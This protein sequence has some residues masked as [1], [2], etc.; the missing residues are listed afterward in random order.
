[1][2][3]GRKV[4]CGLTSSQH[5]AYFNEDRDE[6]TATVYFRNG[7]RTFEEIALPE[8]PRCDEIKDEDPKYLTTVYYTGG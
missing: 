5:V 3:Q 8:F 2:N 1:M 6:H 7:G 4:W